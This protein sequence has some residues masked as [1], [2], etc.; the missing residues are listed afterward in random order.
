MTHADGVP[1]P[2]SV[3]VLF[4][5]LM[6]VLLAGVRFLTHLVAEGRVRTVRYAKG[7]REVLIVGAGEGGRL[8]VRELMRNPELRMR[9]VGFIDDDPRKRRLKDEYGL[10]VLGT[11]RAGRPRARAR[12][13]RAR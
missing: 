11:T 5:L 6:L 4:L 2:A 1:L 13:A 12:R 3:A 9:P 10:R 8:V 7:T